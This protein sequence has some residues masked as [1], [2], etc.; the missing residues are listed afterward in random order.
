[1]ACP[2]PSL[3]PPLL[4]GPHHR[5]ANSQQCRPQGCLKK[6]GTKGSLQKH[7]QAGD[8]HSTCLQVWGAEM[9]L[10]GELTGPSRVRGL[11]TQVHSPESEKMLNMILIFLNLP[12]LVLWPSRWSMTENV[13]YA[14]EKAPCILLLSDGML[15]IYQ[16]GP[17]D[18]MCHLRSVFPYWYSVWMICPLI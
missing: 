9:D 12:K 17:F 3:P 11:G 7:V 8:N 6:K 18:L 15:Y 10:E 5:A 1:M 4:P 13:P 2:R 14:L 16:L